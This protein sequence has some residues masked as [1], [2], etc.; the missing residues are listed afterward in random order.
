MLYI[1]TIQHVTYAY[2]T[3]TFAV[4]SP[5][6]LA[7]GCQAVALVPEWRLICVLPTQGCR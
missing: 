7:R 3:I 4:S 2:L 6:G 1:N 5:A